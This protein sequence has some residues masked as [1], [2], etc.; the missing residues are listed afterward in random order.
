MDVKP[1]QPHTHTLT[2]KRVERLDKLNVNYPV[3]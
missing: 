1:R 3:Q 2:P